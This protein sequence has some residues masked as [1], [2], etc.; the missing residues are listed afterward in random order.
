MKRILVLVALCVAASLS[1]Q[2]PSERYEQRYNMLVSQFGAAGVGVETVLDN[3]AK[4]D[5]TNARLL[6]ARFD[7]LFTKAQSVSVVMKDKKKYLGM[8]PVLTFKDSLQRNVYCYQETFFDDELY[9]QSIKAIDKAIS[10]WP[11][12][13]DFRFVKA[14][15]LISYEKES[16]DMAMGYLRSLVAEAA[17][18]KTDWDYGKEKVGRDFVEDAMQEYCYTLFAIGSAQSRDAFFNLSQHLSETF[19]ENMQF[20][21]NMGSYY[22]LKEDYKTA[23]KYYGKVLKK[24]PEDYSAIKNSALSARK[25]K[26]TKLEIKYL[27]MLVKYGP[28]S[29]ATAAK[30]RLEL[31]SK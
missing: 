16:P 13:L 18:R 2:T 8:E 29:D 1:A 23:L 5:S 10:V 24:N 21:T 4:V 15:S 26:I 31:L 30:A 6:L 11:D 12:R 3:W 20:V 25:M 22:L 28:E 9:G 27:Q 19:P 7:L 14:N 17:A